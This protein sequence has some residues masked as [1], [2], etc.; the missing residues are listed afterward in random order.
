MKYPSLFSG[1]CSYSGLE[2]ALEGMALARKTGDGC[3]DRGL[4]RGRFLFDVK[5]LH[6][7]QASSK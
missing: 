7:A 4:W 3:A 1:L 5:V 2:K 6:I